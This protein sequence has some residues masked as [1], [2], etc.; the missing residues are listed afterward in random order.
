MQVAANDE[1]CKDITYE[2]PAEGLQA[3]REKIDVVRCAQVAP[4]WQAAQ[5]AIA[6]AQQARATVD[7]ASKSG[8]H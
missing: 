5:A 3:L 6:A 4:V 1:A 2:D 7:G 8:A